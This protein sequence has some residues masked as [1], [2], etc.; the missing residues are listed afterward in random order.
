MITIQIN[1]REV[2]DAL[3]ELQRRVDDLRPAMHD[4]GQALTE[5]I[6]QR[7]RDGVD[8]NGRPFAPNSPA[9]LVKK[10][11][12]KPL[13][14]TGNMVGSRLHYAAGR[15][16]VEVGSSAIQ[17]AVLQFGAKRGEFGRTRHGAPLPWGDIPPRPFMPIADG[18]RLPESAR[19]LVLGTIADYLAEAMKR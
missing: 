2:R 13:I 4:I 10:R 12:N 19:R 8:W 5:G 15:D 18:N 3:S 7:I 11:G 16:A 9:T 1:D 17:S 6:V 14:D